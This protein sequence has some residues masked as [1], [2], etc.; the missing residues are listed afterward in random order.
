MIADYMTY[1][2]IFRPMSRKGMEINISP[3]QQMSFESS[4]SFLRSATLSAKMDS[5]ISPSS[6][7]MVGRPCLYGTGSFTLRQNLSCYINN[8]AC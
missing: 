4:L 7:L 2:G 1:D 5:L 8:K 6:R 3:L